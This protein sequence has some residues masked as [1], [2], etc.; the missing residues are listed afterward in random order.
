MYNVKYVAVDSMQGVV[1]FMRDVDIKVVTL[2][3]VDLTVE[4]LDKTIINDGWY[5]PTWRSIISRLLY[6][7][8]DW[9]DIP[10]FISDHIERLVGKGYIAYKPLEEGYIIYDIEDDVVK[11]YGIIKGRE[12]AEVYIYN[13]ADLAKAYSEIKTMQN[14]LNEIDLGYEETGE[15]YVSMMNNDLYGFILSNT[16]LY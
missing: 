2:D 14:L 9:Q 12:G 13:T 10:R 4:M 3:V 7:E 6:E 8:G 5:N 1:D 15:L 11:D 16:D